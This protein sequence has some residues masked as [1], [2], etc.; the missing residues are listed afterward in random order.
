MQK[1]IDLMQINYR[2]NADLSLKDTQ[3]KEEI[4]KI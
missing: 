2:Y 1:S 3:T 4:N